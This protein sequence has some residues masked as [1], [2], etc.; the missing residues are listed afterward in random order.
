[1]KTPYERMQKCTH[2]QKK[3]KTLVRRILQKQMAK[4][5]TCRNCTKKF[6]T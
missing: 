4:K 5:V 1:M 2:T 3:K 6:F